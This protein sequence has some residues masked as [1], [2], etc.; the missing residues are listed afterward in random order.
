MTKRWRPVHR[1]AK[2]PATAADREVVSF[3][4]SAD[5]QT[6]A[7]VL[8]L[9][10]AGGAIERV[11]MSDTLTAG[12]A[13]A[14]EHLLK[15]APS[16][17]ASAPAVA[18]FFA[19][20]P[21]IAA[22]DLRFPVQHAPGALVATSLEIGPGGFGFVTVGFRPSATAIVLYR[23]PTAAA[24][25]LLLA[26]RRSVNHGGPVELRDAAGPAAAASPAA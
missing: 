17:D 18:R 10:L 1:A 15:R 14:L 25:L 2:M 6:R 7:L 22:G 11:A 9:V 24:G 16:M 12:I 23:F 3:R 5:A 20:E 8:K 26:A 4:A 21:E 19:E 13:D